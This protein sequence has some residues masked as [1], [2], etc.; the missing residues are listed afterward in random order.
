MENGQDWQVTDDSDMMPERFAK[1]PKPKM[2]RL[3]SVR[4][5]DSQPSLRLFLDDD[6]P[7]FFAQ[8]GDR[9]LFFK[10]VASDGIVTR[11][12]LFTQPVMYC[13]LRLGRC[14]SCDFGARAKPRIPSKTSW[15]LFVRD[16]T[17][18]LLV[19]KPE[20]KPKLCRG[21]ADPA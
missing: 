5:Q 21:W 7:R 8:E 14:C 11:R 3:Q 13:T 10:A 16:G 15:M 12:N 19:I 20:N 1:K 6:M 2:E 9:E 18:T 17:W 4:A